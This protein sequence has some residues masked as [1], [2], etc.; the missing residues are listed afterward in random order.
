MNDEDFK[1]KVIGFMAKI[2]E[3]FL[4][5][6]SSEKCNEHRKELDQQK[7]NLVIV[8]K[9]SKYRDKWLLAGIGVVGIVAGVKY[10]PILLKMCGIQF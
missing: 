6:P 8:E 5:L 10:F 7:H 4:H 3:K 2:D 1:V 9:D